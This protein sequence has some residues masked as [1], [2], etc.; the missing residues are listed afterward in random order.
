MFHFLLLPQPN[1]LQT[2]K[3]VNA[4]MDKTELPECKDANDHFSDIEVIKSS[5]RNLKGLVY[6]EESGRVDNLYFDLTRNIL[7]NL[8]SF[9]RLESIHTHCHQLMSC[10]FHQ[11]NVSALSNVTEL[12][13]SVSL[14]QQD[15]TSPLLALNR[16]APKLE[17]ICLVIEI[18]DND[19]LNIVSTFTPIL[20]KILRNQTRL[21]LFQIVTVIKALSIN[22]EKRLKIVTEMINEC[23]NVLDCLRVETYTG[24]SKRPLLLRFHVKF[25]CQ[26]AQTKCIIPTIKKNS[27][28]SY[29]KYDCQIF[30]ALCDRKNSM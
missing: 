23:S 26:D 20:Q 1:Q 30:D 24:N 7:S 11:N 22:S 16:W 13:I 29:G 21:K 17:K 5:L 15:R 10:Y 4:S 25:I 27:C 6:M 12:C 14:Q 18:S 2:L 28:T 8:A 3:F 9:K 19:H